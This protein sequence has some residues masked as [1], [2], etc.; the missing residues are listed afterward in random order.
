VGDATLE[1]QE[2]TFGLNAQI[3]FLETLAESF[4][5]FFETTNLHFRLKHK[6]V[7]RGWAQGARPQTKYFRFL[8]S[9]LAETYLKC[10]ILAKIFKNWQALGAFRSQRLLSLQF[11]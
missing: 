9:I 1:L 11:W 10:T 6:G 8:D 7:A 2:T 3:A 5:Y 4:C